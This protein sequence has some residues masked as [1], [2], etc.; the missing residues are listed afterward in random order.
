MRSKETL[1][2][3]TM[4]VILVVLLAISAFVLIYG[5]IGGH[6]SSIDSLRAYISSFGIW[7]PIILT[8][9]QLLQVVLPVLPG[10]MG[11][12]VG[13]ALFGTIG[14]FI[15]NY[16]GYSV[17]SIIAYWL[18]RVYGIKLVSKLIPMKKYEK[19]I[20]RI[21]QSKS[22]PVI[23]F[24]AILLPLAPDDFFCFFSGLMDMKP[25][26]FTAIIL[27]GKPWCILFY[28]LMFEYFI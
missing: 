12:I 28:C 4:I 21:N 16:I 13:A 20:A 5:W 10:F 22:Y 18:A 1:I 14:G 6:F 23:L 27:L 8:L 17:G 7:G 26:K 25:K 2:K 19:L 15:I 3:I 24:L 9:I 11:C